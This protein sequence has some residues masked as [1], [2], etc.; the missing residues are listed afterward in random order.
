MAGRGVP[1]QPFFLSLSMRFGTETL[2]LLKRFQVGTDVAASLYAS[3]ESGFKKDLE[4]LG[5]QGDAQKEHLELFKAEWDKMEM[6][7]KS[8]EILASPELAAM[9]GFITNIQNLPKLKAVIDSAEPEEK[10]RTMLKSFASVIPGL[11]QFL[12]G[13]GF[14]T[15]LTAVGLGSLV[16]P[17][18]DK[19]KEEGDTTVAK[20]EGRKERWRNG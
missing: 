9:D 3:A 1:G 7:K 15:I 10:W 18:K 6:S 8:A 4:E 20:Q 2:I 19:T 5:I 16:K 14:D 13:G 12:D 17:K 11:S